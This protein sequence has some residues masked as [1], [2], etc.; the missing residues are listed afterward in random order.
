MRACASN[1]SM[2]SSSSSAHSGCAE[3][4]ALYERAALRVG[5]L[6]GQD[7]DQID[8]RP[9]TEAAA[10]DELQRTEEDVAGVEAV[11]AEV[12]EEAAEEKRDEPRLLTALRHHS[13]NALRAHHRSAGILLHPVAARRLH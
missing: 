5:V 12:T 2:R 11:R 7:E 4:S 13:R 10:R 1:R 9:D 8:Q 6:A 3:S